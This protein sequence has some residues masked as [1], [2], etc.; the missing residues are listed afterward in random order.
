V[1]PLGVINNMDQT[2]EVVFDKD[3]VDEATIGV[4]PGENDATVWISFS[5]IKKVITDMGDQMSYVEI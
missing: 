1:T 5:D 4:H 3:L 2:V